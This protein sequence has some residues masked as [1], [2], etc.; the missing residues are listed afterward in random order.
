VRTRTPWIIALLLL[1]ALPLRSE[2]PPPETARFLIETITVEG[3]KEAAINIIRAE[4]LLRPGEAYTEDQLRQAVY[5]VHRLPFVLDASFALR[6]GSRRGAYELLIEVQPARWFFFDTGAR[7]YRFGEPLRLDVHG[8]TSTDERYSLSL[9][10]L[11]GAR[12]FVGRSGV[13]FGALDI[14]EGFQAGFT[15]YDLFHKGI[16]ATAGFSTDVCCVREV[17]PLGLDPRFVTW[18]FSNSR[19]LSLNLMIP[20]GGRQSLQVAASDRAGGADARAEILT[21]PAADEVGFLNAGELSYRRAEAKWVY[22]TSDDP[23]FPTRGTTLSAGLEASR[24]AA[25]GLVIQQLRGPYSF[26]PAPP[27]HSQQV[28]AAVSLVRYWSITPRQTLSGSG[29]FA[30]GRSQ[31]RNLL[32]GEIILPS[33]ELNYVGG[34]VRLQHSL[35]L[36][37]SRGTQRVH[38]VRWENSVEF[39]AER[40]SPTLGPSPLRRFAVETALVYRDQWGRVR[41]SLDY[42]NLGK[43]LP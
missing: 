5:R 27:F 11:A 33:V 22:D 37:R 34:S 31:V 15:Q 17:L 20:L 23:S 42:L 25:H 43:I 16:V 3:P 40:N 8:F 9:N 24:F 6:K 10:G 7:A 2:E 18:D 38:D 19:R 35:S 28:V 14:E 29:R 39:G 4:T 1:A 32:D 30:V 36:K 12:L 26:E 41:L 13:L 21:N